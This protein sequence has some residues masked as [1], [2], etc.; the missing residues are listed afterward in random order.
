ML[1]H[2]LFIFQNFS[3]FTVET[4]KY[5]L[6]GTILNKLIR[7]FFGLRTEDDRDNYK[8]KRLYNKGS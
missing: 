4:F 1:Q 7:T 3:I 5:Y 8:N 6:F 2:F